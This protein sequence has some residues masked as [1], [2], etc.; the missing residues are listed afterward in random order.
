MNVPTMFALFDTI[1][2]LDGYKILKGQIANREAAS[3]KLGVMKPVNAVL[4]LL[5]PTRGHHHTMYSKGFY[6]SSHRLSDFSQA[7]TS[8]CRLLSCKQQVA[9][10]SLGDMG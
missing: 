7:Q 4:S 3:W 8:P 5:Q 1:V 9:L 6:C 2:W 10:T